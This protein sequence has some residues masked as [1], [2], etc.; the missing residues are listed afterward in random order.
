MLYRFGN[1]FSF[2]NTQQLRLRQDMPLHFFND[3]RFISHAGNI[4]RYIKRMQRKTIA[5][6]AFEIFRTRPFIVRGSFAG[7]SM[8]RALRDLSLI[9]MRHFARYVVR[10]QC[11][12]GFCAS[13]SST[14]NTNET[15]PS[16]TSINSNGGLM[17]AP[18]QV[19]W[20]G[21]GIL[22]A[23]AGLV[24]RIAGGKKMYKKKRAPF[25]EESP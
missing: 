23:K 25:Q 8:Y 2:H 16:G 3:Y 15:V 4:Q 20:T 1:L 22:S 17:L 7:D 6:N 18:L 9:Q 5:M 11:T 21:I 12:N 10:S 19:Y 24:I 14:I 13:I